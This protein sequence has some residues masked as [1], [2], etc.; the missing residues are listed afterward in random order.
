MSPRFTSGKPELRVCRSDDD[1]AA[2]QQLEPAGE[3]AAVRRADDGHRDVAVEQPHVVGRDHRAV[4]GRRHV[5]ARVGPQ[6]HARAERAV[7]GAGDD[8]A[9]GSRGRTRRRRPSIRSRRSSA[10]SSALRASGRFEPHDEDGAVAFGD[11]LGIGAG[12]ER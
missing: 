2:E 8:D 9:P 1:V 3:R 12:H 5:V 10:R 6:V 11:D 4:L 7:A